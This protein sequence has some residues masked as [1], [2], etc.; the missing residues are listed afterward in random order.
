MYCAHDN[1]HSSHLV[2]H[3]QVEEIGNSWGDPATPLVEE[4]AEALGTVGV[5][6]GGGAVLDPV[7]PLQQQCT[8][9]TVLALRVQ[10]QSSFYCNKC[11]EEQ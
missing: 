8:E 11:S 3:E 6:V 7:A 4:L 2:V 10:Q 5:R 1:D 9:P